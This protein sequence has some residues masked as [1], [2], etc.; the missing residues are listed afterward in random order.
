MSVPAQMPLNPD[1][2][3]VHGIFSNG[4]L[5]STSGRQLEVAC[6]VLEIFWESPV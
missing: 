1:L 3:C 2:K 6:N 4:D 5:I